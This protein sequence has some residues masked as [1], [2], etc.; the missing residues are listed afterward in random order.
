ME[1]ESL[2]LFPQANIIYRINLTTIELA[3]RR[4]LAYSPH[5]LRNGRFEVLLAG[6]YNDKDKSR[7]R[8]RRY[9]KKKREI[10]RSSIVEAKDK[11]QEED[12]DQDQEEEEE[13]EA[14]VGTLPANH[15][16]QKVPPSGDVVRVREPTEKEGKDDSKDE[17]RWELDDGNVSHLIICLLELLKEQR[18][19]REKEKDRKRPPSIGINCSS[20]RGN[21]HVDSELKSFGSFCPSS[22]SQFLTK[23]EQAT[24]SSNGNSSSNSSSSSSSNSNSSSSSSGIVC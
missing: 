4:L 18:V 20:E 3:S 8:D 10:E 1:M 7:E 17:T 9:K 5:P 15:Q 12:Q 13:E 14:M 6:D 23:T 11:D 24:D 21:L 16:E 2:D 22:P 19:E